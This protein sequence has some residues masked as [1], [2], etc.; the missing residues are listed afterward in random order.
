[1]IRLSILADYARRH[2][3]P[4]ADASATQLVLRLSSRMR[5][6]LLQFGRGEVMLE[7]RVARLP[8]SRGAREA[9]VERLLRA[10]APRLRSHA[11]ACTVE[12]DRGGVFLRQ[13][14]PGTAAAGELDGA[15]GAFAQ[16][17]SFWKNVGS[18]A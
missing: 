16:A 14:V 4:A 9:F 13:L 15:V 6:K 5:V 18:K 7:A 8:T 2:D 12:P 17:C 11:Q 1:M 3:L 10:A